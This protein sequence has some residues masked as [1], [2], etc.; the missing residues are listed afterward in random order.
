LLGALFSHLFQS[1]K[2]AGAAL[3]NVFALNSLG[4]ALAPLIISV[5]LFPW[6][7]SKWTLIA[8]S[9][10]YLLL[11]PKVQAWRLAVVV[12]AVMLPIGLSRSDFQLIQRP[13]G[14]SVIE[15]REGVMA[16]VAVVKD[17]LGARTL[18][19][20]NRFQMGGTSAAQA[21]YRQGHIPLLLHPAPK[22][23]LFLGVG[24]GITFAAANLY[25][26]LEADGVELLPEVLDVLP[27]FAPY[28]SF[29]NVQMRLHVADARRWVRTTP[30]TYDVIIADLFH[31]SRDGAG[32]LYTREHFES[33]RGR[34]N[35]GG[36][37]CQWLP[38]HQMDTDT[39]RIIV[40]TFLGIFPQA[41][42]YLL[43]FN[44]DVPVLGLVG[45]PKWPTFSGNWIEARLNNSRLQARLKELS[46]ADSIRF[47]GH[48]VGGSEFLK[49]FAGP[50]RLNTD[51][52]QWVTF[53]APLFSYQSKGG[54][55]APP[56]QTLFSL[57][58][59]SDPRSIAEIGF[60]A[61]SALRLAQFI[62]ARNIYLQGLAHESQQHE[63]EAIDAYVESARISPDFTAGY[64]Q[65]LSKASLWANE[66]P[67]R[68]KALLRRLIQAQPERSVAGELLRRL[69]EA[70]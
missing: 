33:I 17:V 24:T 47:F 27:Q 43:Q 30:Q 7:G 52:Y 58:Q 18:R 20:N 63:T 19:V 39:L 57:L 55:V 8:I 62:L 26:S 51:D 3:G 70:Q 9:S 11:M 2:A 53:R 66:H 32:M 44:V 42:A 50:G 22:A 64:A 38:L 1:A 28:N 46:V 37:F 36:I 35:A 69:E 65:C 59:E 61:D 21:E 15:Y 5:L 23:A 40:R 13:L 48:F 16:S 41:Q 56:Y 31:P 49:R 67:E 4:S 29:S 12:T 14:G 60:D 45:A 6:A 34:L 10:G 54:A 68:A 25:E